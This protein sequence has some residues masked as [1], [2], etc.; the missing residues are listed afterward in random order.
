MIDANGH[1]RLTI[2][3]ED[4][5]GDLNQDGTADAVVVFVYEG[6]GSGVFNYLAAVL[7]ERGEPRHVAT[8]R[9]GDRVEIRSLSLKNGRITVRLVV[10]GDDDPLCCPSVRVERVFKLVGDKFVELAGALKE[11][12]PLFH[13]PRVHANSGL[14]PIPVEEVLPI[15]GK[16]CGCIAFPRRGPLLPTN[17]I[18]SS[19][20]Y[21]GP[22]LIRSEG[23]TLSF[24]R[25]G[26]PQGKRTFVN[27]FVAKEM[28]LISRTREVN[29]QQACA[30]Y[31]DPPT[32]G[33]CFV[34]SLTL[35]ADKKSSSVEIVQVCGC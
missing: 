13:P 1:Q 11:I 27:K 10:Q 30:E 29:Y 12:G 32:E 24:A 6:G 20:S 28:S 19:G 17:V 14:E 16:S 9:L 35:R 7:N 22:H 18:M 5:R 15:Q 34:G 4:L 23:V 8:V 2:K 31:P 3:D 25:A 21:E 26:P 33:S